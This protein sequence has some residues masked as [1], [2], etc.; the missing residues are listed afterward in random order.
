M[1]NL[2]MLEAMYR[3][4]RT[5][6]APSISP[7]CD[8]GW[9]ACR[10]VARNQIEGSLDPIKS[11][12]MPGMYVPA[13][14]GTFTAPSG[15]RSSHVA[16]TSRTT[17][18]RGKCRPISS[19][20]DWKGMSLKSVKLGICSHSCDSRCRPSGFRFDALF[21][22]SGCPGAKVRAGG[23]SKDDFGDCIDP[24]VCRLRLLR[25]V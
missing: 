20:P 23:N 22:Q 24:P 21:P 6:V 2:K 19:M 18:L 1:A 17:C 12:N 11:L 25:T 4:Q 10:R 16:A 7:I 15:R 13:S 8:D 3:A 9:N 14:S 5:I